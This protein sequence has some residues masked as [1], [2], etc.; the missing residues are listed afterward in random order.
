GDE[1]GNATGCGL[2]TAGLA[3]RGPRAGRLNMAS[4]L[5]PFPAKQVISTRL[6]F[7]VDSPSSDVRRTAVLTVSRCSCAAGAEHASASGLVAL[8]FAFSVC[9][10]G[11]DHGGGV[12]SADGDA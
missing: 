7:G 12:G 9:G 8:V 10:F 4:A 11:D 3:R 1:C 5:L 6:A 2:R